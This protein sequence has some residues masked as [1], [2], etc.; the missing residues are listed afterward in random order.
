MQHQQVLDGLPDNKLTLKVCETVLEQCTDFQTTIFMLHYML[1]RLVQCIHVARV[2]DYS[3]RLLG[4]KVRGLF[5]RTV[6]AHLTV[7]HVVQTAAIFP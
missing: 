5:P 7:L 1:T 2:Q 4:A 6:V 3:N